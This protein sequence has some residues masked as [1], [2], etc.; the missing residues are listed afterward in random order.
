[1]THSS[2]NG[3]QAEQQPLE[4]AADPNA[5]LFGDWSYKPNRYPSDPGKVYTAEQISALYPNGATLG[6]PSIH[7]AAIFGA[8]YAGIAERPARIGPNVG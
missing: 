7:Y 6:V 5:D 3:S 4:S 8:D 1:M 2:V